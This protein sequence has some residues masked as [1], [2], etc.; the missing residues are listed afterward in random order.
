MV[1]NTLADSRVPEQ[2]MAQRRVTASEKMGRYAMAAL[3]ESDWFIVQLVVRLC[4]PRL[5]S[6]LEVGTLS[7]PDITVRNRLLF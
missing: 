6:Q 3:C 4:P 1:N 5:A 2:E 7:F